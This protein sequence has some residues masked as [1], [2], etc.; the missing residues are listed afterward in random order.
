[1]LVRY[2]DEL[3]G[4]FMRTVRDPHEAQDLVQETFER[5]LARMQAGEVIGQARPLLFEIARNLLIDRYRRLQVRQHDSDDV[6]GEMPGPSAQ[7]PEAILAGMQRAR[8]LVATIERLPPRC[9]MAFMLHKIEGHSHA[10]V[11]SAM[12]VSV[13]AVER[14]IMLAVAACRKALAAEGER[15]KAPRAA[16]APADGPALDG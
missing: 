10:E 7:E 2:Y 9:R 16:P 1:M 15:V 4:F 13:N 11:A 8:V 5:V 12:G 3:L 14:H 6:L